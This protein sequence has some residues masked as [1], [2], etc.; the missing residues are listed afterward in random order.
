MEKVIHVLL[1]K[2]KRT[3]RLTNVDNCA[4]KCTPLCWFVSAHDFATVDR[5]DPVCAPLK[6]PASIVVAQ[7][8]VSIPFGELRTL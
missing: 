8:F 3:A 5:M 2:G 7:T 6:Q 1:P 4:V